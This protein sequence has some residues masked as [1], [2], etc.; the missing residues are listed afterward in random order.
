MAETKGWG[1]RSNVAQRAAVCVTYVMTLREF[2]NTAM[3]DLGSGN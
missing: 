3:W 1:M 2:I